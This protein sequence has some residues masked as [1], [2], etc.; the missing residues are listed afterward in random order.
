MVS[1]RTPGL[2]VLPPPS[3]P[4]S[5]RV[6]L[7]LHPGPERTGPGTEDRGSWRAGSGG[8]RD[9][10]AA[11]VWR[12]LRTRVR[13]CTH[14]THG[15]AQNTPPCKRTHTTHVPTHAQ[16]PCTRGCA[17][18]HSLSR[19]GMALSCLDLPGEGE[20][21]H[22]SH[23]RGAPGSPNEGGARLLVLGSPPERMV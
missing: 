14:N 10:A 3:P 22:Q 20:L 19:K 23:P 13:T 1:G 15:P 5:N 21:R 16:A 12:A 6:R 2:T 17:D 7:S 11:L 8:L 9:G 4:A 18:R